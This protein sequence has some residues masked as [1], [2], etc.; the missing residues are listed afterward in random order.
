MASDVGAGGRRRGAVVYVNDVERVHFPGMKVK[1]AV[2]PERAKLVA[3]GKLCVVDR[4]G[5]EVGLEGSLE[6]GAKI[7]VLDNVARQSD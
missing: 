2:G 6:P 3:E 4:R 1:F 5:Y 7:Y